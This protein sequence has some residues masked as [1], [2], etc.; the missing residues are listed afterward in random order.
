MAIY[1]VV[2]ESTMD[3]VISEQRLK[4]VKKRTM[5]MPPE[6]CSRQRE[7]MERPGGRT[8]PGWLRDLRKAIVAG[9]EEV[10]E[11]C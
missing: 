3:K 9:E 8:L 4:M 1:G 5:W 6:K 7:Q 2:L 11:E 10:G